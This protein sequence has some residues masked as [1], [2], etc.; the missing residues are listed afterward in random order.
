MKRIVWRH[1]LEG[2]RVPDATFMQGFAASQ[3]NVPGTTRGRPDR[4]HPVPLG[5]TSSA[6]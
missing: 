4:E 3:P 5:D 1:P 2:R 6:R